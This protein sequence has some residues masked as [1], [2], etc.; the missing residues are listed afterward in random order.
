M[1][2]DNLLSLVTFCCNA[3]KISSLLSDINT[4]RSDDPAFGRH[5]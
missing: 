4:V 1:N 5:F 3:L 2:N